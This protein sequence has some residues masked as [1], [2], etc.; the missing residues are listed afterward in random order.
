[1]DIREVSFWLDGR[2]DLYKAGA[3][4]KV[5]PFIIMRTIQ[6]LS[7]PKSTYA[8]ALGFVVWKYPQRLVSTAETSMERSPPLY[9]KI[10]RGNARQG[11]Q[12]RG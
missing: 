11:D 7:R 10:R 1:M 4:D 8:R 9:Y 6:I 5:G 2:A 12:I 3:L